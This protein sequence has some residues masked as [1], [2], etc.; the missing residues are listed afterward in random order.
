MAVITLPSITKPN[1]GTGY[2]KTEWHYRTLVGATESE[3]T[4]Q[5]QVTEWPGDRLGLDCVLPPMDRA[6]AADWIAFL[7]ECDGGL[8]TFYLGPDGLEKQPRGTAGGTPLVDGGSQTGKT[9]L[10]KG[11]SGQLLKGDFLQVNHTDFARLYVVIANTS[12]VATIKI[13]PRIRI[14]S[15]NDNAA[16]TFSNPVGLFRLMWGQDISWSLDQ[17]QKYGVSFKVVEA[18]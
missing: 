8:N 2:M 13:R 17:A 6:T 9:I 18:L 15:P 11:W 7:L 16:C 4:M 3:F 1:G 10:L 12:A 5:Q 14:P